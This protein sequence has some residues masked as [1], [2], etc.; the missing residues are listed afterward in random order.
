MAISASKL[1]GIIRHSFPNAKIKISD[2]LGDQDHYSL[3]IE[4]SSFTGLSL[5][6]Q[7]KMVKKAL[8]E[9]M[10]SNELHAITIKT[11]TSSIK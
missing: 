5:V 3:E 10:N 8:S 2:Y 7:H 4:D 1:E 11:S 9:I 6:N